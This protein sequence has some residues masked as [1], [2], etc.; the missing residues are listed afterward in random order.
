MDKEQ[1]WTPLHSFAMGTVKV[2][3]DAKPVEESKEE[4]DKKDG[5]KSESD[6]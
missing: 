6:G 5:D 2:G 3:G 1:A 4:E